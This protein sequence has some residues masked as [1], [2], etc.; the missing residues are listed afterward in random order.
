MDLTNLWE[1]TIKELEEN[2]F[3]WSDVQKIGTKEG[4]IP[5]M[6][7][8]QFAKNYNYFSGYGVEYVPLDLVI[9]GTGFRM[10]RKEYDGSEWWHII[11]FESFINS[12]KVIKGKDL[13][14]LFRDPTQ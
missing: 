1:E 2:G 13:K 4:F 8:Q 10:V 9:E 14:K 11:L 3:S 7:F 6:Y 12:N 5:K